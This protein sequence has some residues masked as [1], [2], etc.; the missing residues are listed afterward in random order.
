MVGLCSLKPKVDLVFFAVLSWLIWSDRN[1]IIVGCDRKAG[2]ELVVAASAWLDSFRSLM[3]EGEV[4]P[5]LQ[6]RPW[7]KPS[8]DVVKIN[9]DAAINPC[10]LKSGIGI[11]CR[12][13]VGAVMGAVAKPVFAALQVE[14]AEA[15]ALLEG[16]KFAQGVGARKVEVESDSLRVVGLFHSK[17][18]PLA[19]AGVFIL[20]CWDVAKAFDS[21]SCSHI[22]RSANQAAHSI[23]AVA[24]T[25][26][27]S[28]SWGSD[29]PDWIKTV[30]SAD[31][32]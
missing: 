26:D 32:F 8:A 7:R 23:A 13:E 9:V 24:V 17:S 28:Q 5:F 30:A 22:F 16:F 18:P 12:N 19:D 11:I 10:T 14:E 29:V 27:Y 3:V 6:A 15:L 1:K 25:L 31:L 4:Q 2:E 20:D 21:V